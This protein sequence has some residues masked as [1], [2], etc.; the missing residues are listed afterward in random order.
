[1]VRSHLGNRK[2][3][4]RR[5][6]ILIVTLLLLALFATVG[7]TIV[8]YTR[9]LA[10]QQQVNAQAASTGALT[11]SDDGSMAF[12][13]FLSNLIYGQ[14]NSQLS[15]LGNSN[16][17]IGHDL[18]RSIYGGGPVVGTVPY[19]GIPYNAT[20][21]PYNWVPWNGVGTFHEAHTANGVNIDRAVLVNLAPFNGVI[22]P[23]TT[24]RVAPGTYVPKN[25]PYTYP[26]INNFFLASFVP[27]TGEVLVPSFYRSYVFASSSQAPTDPVTG[28][29]PT[30]L[31]PPA[32]S[33]PNP[34]WTTQLPEFRALIARPRPI[35][36]PLRPGGK[37]SAFP[38]PPPN[39]DGT[40]TGDVQNLTGSFR[41][42]P[43]T[44]Q[45]V[46]Y[47][48]SIWIDIGLPPITLPNGKTVKPL[49][50][51]L[52]IDLDALLNYNVHGNTSQSSGAGFG[53]WEINIAK[54]FNLTVSPGNKAPTVPTTMT[55][56]QILASTHTGT[57]MLFN[58][59]N[60][61]Q[62]I[63]AYSDV[64]WL[65]QGGV[66][67]PSPLSTNT[68]FYLPSGTNN[69]FSTVP[70]YTVGSYDNNTNPNTAAG[71]TP[72]QTLSLTD[73][74]NLQ[75]LLAQYCGTP[76]IYS[77]PFATS[78]GLLSSPFTG[79]T[80]GTNNYS[81]L[82]AIQG[83]ASVWT[84]P[85]PPPTGGQFYFPSLPNPQSNIPM[86]GNANTYQQN[87]T[88]YRTDPAAGNR[89]ILTPYS[90]NLDV[91]GLSPNFSNLTQGKT[92]G[93][94]P[95]SNMTG[96]ILNDPTAGAAFPNPGTPTG[97]ISDFGPGQWYN[98]RAALGP[99]D[100]NRPLADYRGN[101]GAQLSPTNMI[102]MPAIVQRVLAA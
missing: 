2:S 24:H 1:M 59:R 10:D 22:Q 54:P 57:G 60:S 68:T 88:S 32:S 28:T 38:Y 94:T 45:Y 86:P 55:D 93:L 29:A 23:E 7:L 48:D 82:T 4:K 61:G 14:P 70:S 51:P 78:G 62:Q 30:G 66:G 44:G 84:T 34:N 39:A 40:Y 101:T 69:P 76:A 26:D 85:G 33:N 27:A 21:T 41:F 87:L 74:Q 77:P 99:I 83:Q 17:I 31:E 18:M 20:Q 15:A 95:G 6:N 58:W 8:Y 56:G 42:N 46:A 43:K 65:A 47:N 3:G 13:E 64:P 81:A 16:T 63:P 12:N 11:F 52:I 71:F 25:A 92:L 73:G 98:T 102:G 19:N 53:P 100:M 97:T 80:V 49:V 36:N 91:P 67:P 5:G 35:D 90:F 96:G 89:A 37:T 50:A 9:D 75:A 79:Y 72:P